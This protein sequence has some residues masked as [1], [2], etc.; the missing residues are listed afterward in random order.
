M[1]PIGNLSW[2]ASEKS[3]FRSTSNRKRYICSI[4]TYREH[5]CKKGEILKTF[6]NVR[7]LCVTVISSKVWIFTFLPQRK[8]RKGGFERGLLFVVLMSRGKQSQFYKTGAWVQCRN[9]YLKSVGGLC[10]KC[11]E[12]GLIVPAEIVHHKIHL[13]AENLSDPSISLNPANL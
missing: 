4:E 3:I 10:E 13:N 7:L 12:K 8:K 6:G 1:C 5:F 11:L 9:A 2:K